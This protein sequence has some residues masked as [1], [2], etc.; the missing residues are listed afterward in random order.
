MVE[1]VY[2]VIKKA[3]PDFNFQ[4]DIDL[5]FEDI[6]NLSED[7]L[8]M[9]KYSVSKGI[10]NGRN[11]KILDL[12]TACT[13]QELMVY[14]KNAYEFVVY[15]AGL[16]SKGAFWEVSYNGNTV[17]L[18]G[19]M[20]YADSSIYPLSKDILNA[21]EASDILVLEVGPGNREDPSLYMMERGM[22][23]DE[24]TLEQNIPEEVYEMFVETIQPY[25]IQEEFYN[26]L[27]PWYAG[28]LITGLNMEA[29][30][31][32]AGLGIEMFFT[33]KAMGTKEIMEIE[34]IKFQADMLD[35]FS[36]EL[37]I[38]FLKWALAEIEEEESIETVD[39]ILES[40]KNGDAEQL[41]K[42]LRGNDDGDNEA[43]KEY[44]KKMW[45]ER[46]N[47]MTKKIKEYLTDS[48]NIYFVVVGAG[49]MVGETG[50]IAQLEKEGIYQIKQVK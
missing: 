50:I 4:V 3:Q 19:S 21:F 46:D 1:A 5:T 16:D 30:S 37:Q 27:K 9:V 45:E 35:S 20:H 48:E 14:A 11:N 13:R 26:K 39:K 12:S 36:E 42:L 24:N 6:D 32:S 25:G 34:G 41:A 38:E 23:Q 43:L 7:L 44:N 29:N 15:E 8:D 2:K 22:Y 18:F 31:Y 10:L 28:F 47:N 17:Y 40:W 49:H 33:L